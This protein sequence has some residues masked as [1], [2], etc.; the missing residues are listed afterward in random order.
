MLKK[1]KPSVDISVI[2]TIWKRA[3]LDEQI[4]NIL[5]QT[6]KPREIIVVQCCNFVDLSFPDV[7]SYG[8][9]LKYVYS[10]YDFGYFFRFSTAVYAESNYVYIM[11]DDLV[12]TKNWLNYIFNICKKRN[13]IVSS[14]GRILPNNNY[15]QKKIVILFI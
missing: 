3:H 13:V 4:E 5:S 7:E 10:S 8:I 2:L 11:D 12:P 9:K 14:S 1:A 6:V 15:S